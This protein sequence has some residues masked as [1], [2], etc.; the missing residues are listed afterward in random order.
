MGPAP[1]MLMKRDEW[2][3]ILTTPF[4]HCIA[5]LLISILVMAAPGARA[6]TTQ[7]GITVLVASLVYP[8]HPGGT[9]CTNDGPSIPLTYA[10]GRLSAVG[11][12]SP[13]I[14]YLPN[15]MVGMVTHGTGSGQ[16]IE[17]WTPDPSGIER[18]LRIRTTDVATGMEL[19]ASGD[20]GYDGSGNVTRIG[21][22]RY[23]YDF[24]GR[25]GSFTSDLTRAGSGYVY[26]RFGNRLATT[27]GYCSTNPDGSVRCGGTTSPAEPILGT[28]NHYQNV[29]YDAAGNV[30]ADRGG[31]RTFAYDS[32]GMMTRAQTAGRDFHF[33]YTAD[34]ERVAVVE[35]VG[36]ANRTTWS[37]RNF[38]RERKALINAARMDEVHKGLE[39]YRSLRDRGDHRDRSLV[40][41]MPLFE[42]IARHGS[43]ASAAGSSSSRYRFDPDDDFWLSPEKTRPLMASPPA[44]SA[45]MKRAAAYAA[46]C[47]AVR[48]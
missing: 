6:A 34:D 5:R 3:A 25:L 44:G 24:F 27:F 8:C 4:H 40:G 13:S 41:A 1:D 32:L 17:S 11:S 22:T 21:P 18:P 48:Q 47:T 10:N 23:S 16:T 43:G 36:S 12:Y 37:I 45:C 30:T 15:G 7:P 28:T 39:L 19:W 42:N 14:T 9:A 46:V 29:S 20:Y 33:L 2:E 26:D 35:R 31:A 38:Q